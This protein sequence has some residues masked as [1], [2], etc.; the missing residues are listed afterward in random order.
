MEIAMKIW[1]AHLT[2]RKG[3]LKEV[4]LRKPAQLCIRQKYLEDDVDL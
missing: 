1:S 2:N 3:M 4:A